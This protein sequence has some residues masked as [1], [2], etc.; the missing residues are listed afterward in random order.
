MGNVAQGVT[1]DRQPHFVFTFTAGS[2]ASSANGTLLPNGV[3]GA[4][5]R[6]MPYRGSVYAIAAQ[7]SGTIGGTLTLTP[8]IDGVTQ[9][10]HATQGA[11]GSLNLVKKQDGRVTN[12]NAGST[13]SVLYNTT[14]VSGGLAI[15]VDVY[16]FS[17]QV[18]I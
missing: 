2:L 11:A 18:E 7:G 5:K 4:T 9:T 14:N 12:Y 8:V 16:C 13:L 15:V 1:G 10:F 17:E 6:V 3:T